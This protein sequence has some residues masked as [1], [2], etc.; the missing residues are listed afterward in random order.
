MSL[1]PLK[2]H[3]SLD[4]RP[5]WFL[6]EPGYHWTEVLPNSKIYACM[7][8]Y[9]IKHATQQLSKYQHQNIIITTSSLEHRQNVIIKNHQ[10]II[11]K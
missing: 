7:I 1:V 6:S 5:P 4:V 9:K 8:M 3:P 2:P 11:I 10:D